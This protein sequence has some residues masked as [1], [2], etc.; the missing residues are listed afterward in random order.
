MIEHSFISASLRSALIPNGDYSLTSFDLDPQW[1]IPATP[2]Y[3]RLVSLA[4]LFV[5]KL[6]SLRQA[7]L[8]QL[9]STKRDCSLRSRS[10]LGIPATPNYSRLVSLT[11]L[12]VFKL[13]SL[14]QAWL[15]Q[16]KNKKP[17]A[18]RLTGVIWSCG[19]RGIRTP[20]PAEAGQR[21][22]RPPHSTAL[23]SL[24]INKQIHRRS[25]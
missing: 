11:G 18:C 9:V 14:R 5:F 7:W 21:F 1:G 22:S 20:G 23:A 24:L 6:F 10:L 2:N 4:G 25:I 13:F 19:E 16:L 8:V 15:V 12:F 3:S 17:S